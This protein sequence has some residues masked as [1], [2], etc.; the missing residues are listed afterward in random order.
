MPVFAFQNGTGLFSS[1]NHVI[2]AWTQFD[3]PDNAQA[4]GQGGFDPCIAPAELVARYDQLRSNDSTRPVFLNFGQGVSFINWVGRGTCTGDTS[5]YPKASPAGDIVSSDIYPVTHFH[6][7]VHG[8]LE[9]VGQGVANLVE[10]SGAEKIIWNFIETTHIN[11]PTSRPTPGQIRTE[12]WMSIIHGSMGIMYF[13]HEWEPSF[14]E[15]GIFRYPEIVQGVRDINADVTSLAPVLNSMTVDGGAQIEAAVP[16][17]QIVKEYD[18]S[19]YLFAVAMRN[20]AGVATFTLAGGGEGQVEVI[21]ADRML[22]LGDGQ[23]QDSFAGY[24]VHLYKISPPG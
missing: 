15:N 1:R 18:G 21:G 8:N 6:P 24:G 9:F 12:V 20:Q 2:P 3:E 10:W 17:A 4:D 13:V 16:M 5:Y 22:A 7:T 23:F 19:I 14:C 11:H